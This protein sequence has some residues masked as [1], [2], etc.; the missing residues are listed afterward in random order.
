[1][2][3]R[4]ALLTSGGLLMALMAGVVALWL[5]RGV[6]GAQASSTARIVPKPIVKT[7]TQIVTVHKQRPAPPGSGGGGQTITIVRHLPPTSTGSGSGGSYQDD[8]TEQE[9]A[10]P[11][12]GG[13]G[14]D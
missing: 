7:V 1:M 12:S 14:D 2:T 5:G 4:S 10:D 8:S 13:G 6:V 11:G 3:K 9:V